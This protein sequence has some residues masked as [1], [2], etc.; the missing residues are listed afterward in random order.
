MPVIKSAKKKLR[1]DSKR[2]KQNDSIRITLARLIKKAKKNPSI[3]LL[4]EVSRTA[5]KAAK[6]HIIHKNKA[7]RI[8][9]SLAKIVSVKPVKTPAK[10]S[11]K[12]TKSSPP[13][14]TSQKINI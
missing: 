2:E 6:K 4:A 7:A 1:Q 10:E 14:K 8:K 13:K 11:K 5:D 9:S 12:L 3:K